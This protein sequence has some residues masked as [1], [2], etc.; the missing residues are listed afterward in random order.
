MC[1]VFIRSQASICL[2][3]SE[4][5]AVAVAASFCLLPPFFHLVEYSE[6]QN[7]WMQTLFVIGV[8]ITSFIKITF[9]VQIACAMQRSNVDIFLQSRTIANIFRSDRHS[10]RFLVVIIQDY[11]LAYINYS[12]TSM[13]L[14]G[15]EYQLQ[16][17]GVRYQRI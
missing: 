2:L 3:S 1:S 9:P 15:G 7:S 12:L 10:E 4:I 14:V 11:L 8:V 17:F 16:V 5:Y 13:Q 6:K